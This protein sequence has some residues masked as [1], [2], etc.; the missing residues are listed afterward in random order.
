MYGRFVVCNHPAFCMRSFPFSVVIHSTYLNHEQMIFGLATTEPL[1]AKVF[2][3]DR[4]HSFQGGCHVVVKLVLS[5]LLKLSTRL[6]VLTELLRNDKGLLLQFAGILCWRLAQF[7]CRDEKPFDGIK[8]QAC[9][10]V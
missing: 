6:G 1:S 10:L 9:N 4:S 7:C 8:K 2:T 3:K 5:L